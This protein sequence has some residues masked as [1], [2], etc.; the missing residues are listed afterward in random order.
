VLGPRLPAVLLLPFGAAALASFSVIGGDARW[1][2]AVGALVAG[3]HL[4][5]SLPF[6]TASTEGWHDAPALGQL[7]F[8]VLEWVAGDRALVAAHAF[9]A[10]VGFG[11][12][13][14]VIRRSGGG[15]AVG[16]IVLLAALPTLFLSV[17]SLFSLALFPLLLLLLHDGRRLWLAVPLFALWANLYGGVLV[18]WALLAV[19]VVFACRRAWP[20]LALSTAALFTT[21]ALWH[22]PDYYRGVFENEAAKRGMGMWSPLDHT[23]FAIVLVLAAVALAVAA[24]RNWYRWEIVAAAGLAVGTVHTMRLGTFLLFVLAAPAA[25]GRLSASS[26]TVPLAFAGVLVLAVVVGVTAPRV[27]ARVLA[28]RVAKTGKPV[29]GDVIAS[30]QVE[31]L[32]GRVWVANPLDAFSPADQKLYVDWL[33]ARPAGSPAVEHAAYVLVHDDTELSAAASRDPRLRVEARRDG[34]VLFARR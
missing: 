8:H 22:T 30:E 24:G 5:G 2:A 19:Y 6:A 17:T 29:L 3:G 33:L 15:L 13:G 18:G 4:P 7:V 28:E 12:L 10:G 14:T 16:A 32:G 21:A 9:A 25:R 34:Y 26:R 27:D 1:Y 11:A 23:P 20:V 31:L